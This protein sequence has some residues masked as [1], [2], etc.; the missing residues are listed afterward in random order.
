MRCS[1]SSERFQEH[2][3]RVA[4]PIAVWLRVGRDHTRLRLFLQQHIGVDVYL[5]GKVDSAAL[6][7][8]RF[9]L[10]PGGAA[11][12]TDYA[13]IPSRSSSFLLAAWATV[14]GGG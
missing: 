4:P 14:P 1:A 2:E 13:S 12:C 11:S 8:R 10:V 5:H 7:S 6:R 9:Y 3:Q